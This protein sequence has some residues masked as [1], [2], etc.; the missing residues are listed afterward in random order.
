MV[1]AAAGHGALAVGVDRLDT[2]AVRVKQEAAVVV[3]AVDRARPGRAA[4]RMTGVDPRLPEGADGRAVRRAEADVQAAGHRVLA[5]HRA[6]GPV[7]PLDQAGVRVA[8]LDAE[9]G[10]HGAI[11]ALGR[12]EVGHGEPHVVK[13]RPEA[14]VRERAFSSRRGGRPGAHRPAGT[15]EPEATDDQ[16]HRREEQRWGEGQAGDHVAVSDARGDDRDDHRDGEQAGGRHDGSASRQQDSPYRLEHSGEDLQCERP[17]EAE[18]AK[19]VQLPMVK[20]ELHQAG[21]DERDPGKERNPP[22]YALAADPLIR[23]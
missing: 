13:H 11:E 7:L 15:S 20:D 9:H 5:V 17:G 4:V 19:R 8:R 10:E 12:G 6:D 3:R 22:G 18:A 2:V 16:E 21:Y 14:T 1:D 23:R